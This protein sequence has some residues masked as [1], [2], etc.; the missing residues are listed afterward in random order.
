MNVLLKQRYF[1]WEE[2]VL[3][4]IREALCLLGYVDPPKGHG[5]RILSIDGGGVR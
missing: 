4:Y 2:D 3:S 5:L 1:S